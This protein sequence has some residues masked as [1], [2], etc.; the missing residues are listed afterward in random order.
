M[1]GKRV[2][3]VVDMQQG[4]FATPRIQ[5]E[6]CVAQINRLTLAADQVI[7]IQ[8]AEAGGLEE[9]SE[10]FALLPELE[11]PSGALFVTKTACDAF[12]RTELEQVLREHAI[13]SFVM[14]G[15]AT[16]YCVDTTLKNGASRGYAIT[17][18][19]DAHTTAN[20]PAAP[21]TTLIAHY[22][23]VWRNLTVPGNPVTVKPVATILNDWQT[24]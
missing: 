7:F 8:H 9:G 16:D 19:E 11:Q 6:Q 18:A 4:V 12:Y 13:D 20:R 24:N 17:V 22:N 3:M 14:C 5:R 2:V 1:A 21:A 10:G 23:E 15:C